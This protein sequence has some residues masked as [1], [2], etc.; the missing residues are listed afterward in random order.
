MVGQTQSGENSSSKSEQIREL[1]NEVNEIV[2]VGVDNTT[3]A[4]DDW[5]TVL[6]WSRFTSDLNLACL[7]HH[8]QEGTRC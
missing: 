8:T 3:R 4:F 7:R 6:G 1:S 2:R 5:R